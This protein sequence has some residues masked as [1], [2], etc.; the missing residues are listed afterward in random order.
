MANRA[1]AARITMRLPL[2]DAAP[3]LP[4]CRAGLPQ[5]KTSANSGRELKSIAPRIY[6]FLFSNLGPWSVA[7]VWINLGFPLRF[8]NVSH[9][10]VSDM[11]IAYLKVRWTIHGLSD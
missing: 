11:G 9:T 8:L 5:Q 10:K 3:F 1:R 7:A 6:V 2:I 4:R